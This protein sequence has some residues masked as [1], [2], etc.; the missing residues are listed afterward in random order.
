MTQLQFSTLFILG[1]A[2]FASTLHMD[3]CAGVNIILSIISY[4]F[5]I[6]EWHANEPHKDN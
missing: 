5:V 2:I 1:L 6:E 4:I 3:I